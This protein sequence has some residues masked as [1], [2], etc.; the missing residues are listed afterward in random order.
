MQRLHFCYNSTLFSDSF[1]AKEAFLS[2]GYSIFLN[3]FVHKELGYLS[4]SLIKY[5]LKN[6]NKSQ[7]MRF[8]YGLCRRDEATL[9]VLTGRYVCEANICELVTIR[10]VSWHRR[11][12]EIK[13][14][15]FKKFSISLNSR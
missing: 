1:I 9:P 10:L 13:D 11:N 8:Y 7:R 3:K 4:F 12:R 14:F 6:L 15:L 5:D 2:E